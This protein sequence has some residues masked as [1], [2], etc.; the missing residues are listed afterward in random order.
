MIDPYS[1]SG[2]TLVALFT[3][4]QPRNWDWNVIKVLQ[5]E[6]CMYL[7]PESSLMCL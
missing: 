5:V 6:T 7:F 4:E 1:P 3:Q 2:P